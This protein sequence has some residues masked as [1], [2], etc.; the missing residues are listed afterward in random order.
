[1]ARQI[2]RQRENEEERDER[3]DQQGGAGT[4]MVPDENIADD[5]I[6]VVL[7]KPGDAGDDQQ[8]RRDEPRRRDVDEDAR[9]AYDEGNDNEI[10]ER[11]SRRARRNRARREAVSGRDQVIDGLQQ[12]VDHLTNV[13]GQMGQSQIGLTINGIEQQLNA[14][15]QALFLADSE[16]ERAITASDGS[17]FREVQKLRDEAAA[18]VCQLG[19]ARQRLQQEAQQRAQGG[20]ADT[21]RQQQAPAGAGLGERAQEFTQTFMSRF[22]YFDP[23]GTDEDSLIIKGIDDAV[24]A[25]GYRPD[26]PL[27][28]RTLEQ[29][30]AKRGFAPDHGDSSGDDDRGGSRNDQGNDSAPVRRASGGGRPPSSS[31]RGGNPATG[32]RFKLHPMMVDHL[33]NEGLDGSDLAPEDK[34]R[35]DRLIAGWRDNERKAA[36][37]EFNRK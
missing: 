2:A 31:G 9:L 13:L 25:E 26:T 18:R 37:G 1:M 20:Q 5:S 36:K 4:V 17:R 7:E 8:E 3:D 6:E 21:R 28:W 35:R 33:R 34:A 10:E 11:Q 27:Y 15:Q 30:L 32:A 29:R 22:S 24:A 14:A 12:K 19:S 16:M 23:N